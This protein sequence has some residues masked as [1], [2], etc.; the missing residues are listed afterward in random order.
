MNKSVLNLWPTSLSWGLL[1]LD[2]LLILIVGNMKFDNPL[3]LLGLAAWLIITPIA[4]CTWLMIRYRAFFRT[5]PGWT[6]PIILLIFSS[7]VVQG[8]LPIGLGNISLIFSI[9][10]IVSLYAVGLATAILL[11]YRDV[12][13]KL[14]AWW[15][16]I[17]IWTLTLAWRY[18][19]NLIELAFYKLIHPNEPD[20]IWWFGPFMCILWWIIPLGIISFLGHTLRIIIREWW[21]A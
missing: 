17:V 21:G 4:A 7:S 14:V 5:W 11:W 12:G 10:S 20:P 16:V 8:A 19:G 3:L 13:L 6:T 1:I 15:T 9:L 18:Q 2:L